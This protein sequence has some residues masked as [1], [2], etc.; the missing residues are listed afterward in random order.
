[1][2]VII[3]GGI[4]HIILLAARQDKTVIK[5]WKDNAMETV[6][7]LPNLR[8]LSKQGIQKRRLTLVSFSCHIILLTENG[9]LLV[10]KVV[11]NWN[12]LNYHDSVNSIKNM[13]THP[14]I[15]EASSLAF[16]LD[17]HAK[18]L[19]DISLTLVFR[20]QSMGKCLY[21]FS[22]IYKLLKNARNVL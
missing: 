19:G 3:Y 2:F 5:Y 14:V 7:S 6:M 18:G 10:L 9:N 13:I 20:A 17:V 21:F 16:S 15:P 8:I 1:M 12:F 11:S 4:E 22:G